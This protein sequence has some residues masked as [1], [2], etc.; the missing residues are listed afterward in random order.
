[1]IFKFSL[2]KT[3]PKIDCTG[4]ARFIYNTILPFIRYSQSHRLASLTRRTRDAVT[5]KRTEAVCCC[6]ICGPAKNSLSV[7]RDFQHRQH[8]S[9][10]H[11]I[12]G[13]W[14]TRQRE[15]NNNLRLVY[16]WNDVNEINSVI[17]DGATAGSGGYVPPL[18]ENMGL[19]I[20]PNLQT[21]AYGARERPP[22]TPDFRVPPTSKH[23][24]PSLS[25]I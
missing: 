5:A 18:F 17:S 13:F 12:N 10:Q 1:M 6:N 20:S 7:V 2:S 25:V 15:K 22:V 16:L 21:C 8:S 3:Y 19:V 4:D 9:H 11:S 24:A 14:I 23:L